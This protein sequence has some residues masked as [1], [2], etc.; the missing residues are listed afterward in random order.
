MEQ[1]G[2]KRIDN[3]EIDIKA[4]R[5][6]ILDIDERLYDLEAAIVMLENTK[7]KE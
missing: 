2:T 3:I 1:I 4:L 5:E 7:E 6:D